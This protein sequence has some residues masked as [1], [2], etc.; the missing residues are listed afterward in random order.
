MS[1]A[2]ILSQRNLLSLLGHLNFA[3]H[4]IPQ[5][6]SF[7]SQL[8]T[9]ANSVKNLID[10]VVLDDSCRSDLRFW[11]LLCDEWNGISFFYNDF[12]VL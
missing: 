8:L 6:H 12:V 10:T 5:G 4:I 2:T 1:A 9:L 3:M 11:P 7:V